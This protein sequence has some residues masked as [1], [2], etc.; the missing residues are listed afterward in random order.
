[1]HNMTISHDDNLSGV[2]LVIDDDENQ[3]EIISEILERAG[4]KVTT[5]TNGQAGLRHI[6]KQVNSAQAQ[7]NFD[8][9]VTDLKMNDVNGIQILEQS[10]EIMPDA[11]V[12]IIT[13][14]GTVKTA[15]EAM[16]KGS[17]SFISKPLNV[18]E[19]RAKVKR[20]LEHVHMIKEN[21]ELRKLVDERFGFEGIIGESPAMQTVFK[22]LKAVAPT[23][24]TVL[25][26]GES[27]TG[28]ELIARALHNNSPRK[29]KPY[30]PINC[31]TLE[32]SLL[33]SE[34]FGHKKGS[35]TGAETDRAGKFEH[36]NE[37]TLFLDEVGDMPIETQVKLLR[38]IEDKEVI[39]IGANTSFKVNVRII[40][41]TNQDLKKLVKQGKFRDDL[42]NRLN[43][44]NLNLPALVERPGD[45]P[46]LAQHFLIKYSKDFNKNIIGFKADALSQLV[47]FEFPG[48]VRQLQNIIQRLV[49][50]A[51]GDE[52]T[53]EEIEQQLS[54]E[55]SQYADNK[56][57]KSIGFVNHIG[58]SL[59]EAEEA[60]IRNTL[61]QQNN[62][63]D[64]TA[65]ILGISSRTL[66]RKLKQLGIN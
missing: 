50:F 62:N 59:Q 41:A 52:V 13:A 51:Q 11:A 27:G 54:E 58:I 39:R 6:R 9:V 8:V 45:I 61:E 20:A 37:G 23:D 65:K 66:Y 48:N 42:Y 36:A 24:A 7:S 33:M 15:V 10:K 47:Q 49:L 46:L 14:H 56:C 40:A 64:Q 17:Y 60:L 53:R 28:K 19:L 5:A 18:T 29:N 25:I 63:R 21:R 35:F 44:I 2:V 34:L 12:I 30:V 3:A 55:D 43:V 1:M 38:V 16:E 4:H 57:N 32:G 31:S 22:K 26:T